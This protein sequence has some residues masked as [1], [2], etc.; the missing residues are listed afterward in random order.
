MKK[1][2]LSI[3]ILLF[4]FSAS[5]TVITGNIFL[6]YIKEFEDNNNIGAEGFINGYVAGLYDAHEP[7]LADCLGENVTMSS[8]RDVVVIYLKN[9]PSKRE[10]GVDSYFVFLI[11]EQWNCS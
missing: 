7:E 1:I 10:W 6:D 5:A 4:S 3:S 2:I 11:K 9:N 8:L